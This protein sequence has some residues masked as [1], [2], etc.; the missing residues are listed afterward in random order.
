MLSDNENTDDWGMC[1]E[2][3]FYYKKLLKRKWRAKHIMATYA[4]WP[5]IMDKVSESGKSRR[6]RRML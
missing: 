4:E 5:R 1:L 2:M 6:P 3:K